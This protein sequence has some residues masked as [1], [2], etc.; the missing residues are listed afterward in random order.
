MDGKTRLEK[1]TYMQ[2]EQLQFRMYSPEE[3]KKLSVLQIN[4]T[5]TFD[6]SGFPISGGLYD[7]RLGPYEPTDV[8]QTCGLTGSDC[9]GHYGHICLHVPVFNPMLFNFTYNLLKGSCV[10]CHQF[11]CDTKGLEANALLAKLYL[12]NVGDLA[13]MAELND[14]FDKEGQIVSTSPIAMALDGTAEA[15]QT[16]SEL[17]ENMYS[18]EK[19]LEEISKKALNSRNIVTLRNGL[20]RDYMRS[21]LFKRFVRCPKCNRRNG[22]MKNDGARCILIDFSAA[23]NKA[24]LKKSTQNARSDEFGAEM[25]AL[26]A[27]DDSKMVA[28]D[29]QSVELKSSL[30]QQMQGLQQGG[31]DKLAWRASEVREHFRLLWKTEGNF[32]SKLFPMFAL[33]GES[34][35]LD[36]LFSDVVLVPPSKFRP[37]RF[38]KGDNYEHPQTVNL[39]RLLESSEIMNA[40]TLLMDPKHQNNMALKHLVSEKATG[41]TPNERLHN[42]YLNLQLRMNAIFDQELDPTDKN[43]PACCRSV[44]TPDPYL[45]VDEIGIPEIFAKKLT[46]PEPVNVFNIT[47]LRKA[48][49]N[50]PGKYPGANAVLAP[51]PNV[52]FDGEK[53]RVKREAT[54]K[55]LRASDGQFNKQDVV[56]RQLKRGDVLLMNRQPSLHK[57]SIMGHRARILKGQRALRMNYA[58]CKA[59]NADFDGDEMNGHLVQNN[60]AQT[61]ARSLANVGS[62]FLVPKDGTP[63]LGLIQDHVVSGVLMT[64]RGQFFSKEDFM[65]LLLAAFAETPKRLKIPPP[66]IIKPCRMWS[67]KQVVSAIV[68]NSLPKDAPPI[69]LI[70]KS[71]TPLVCWQVKGYDPPKME[72]SES[73]I[74]F[75]E[76]ELLCGVL[77]KSHFGATQ[78]GLIHCCFELYGPT[79][80]VQILS[81]FSRVFTT[82]LQFHGFTL[83][84]ADIIV[85]KE[86]DEARTE[87]IKELRTIGEE[88]VRSTFQLDDT[89]SEKKLK[90][91]LATAYNNPRRETQDVQQLDYSMKKSLDPF[92]KRISDACVPSGLIRSF[93]CNALQMMIQSGAKGSM[94]NS[95]QIS[96]G[97]GQ[98]ELEGHRPPLTAAGRTLPSFKAFDPSPRAGGYVDQR[99]LTGIN[100]QE[101]FFHTMAGREGL[102]DTAVKTSRSGYLQRCI[103]KHLEGIVVHYDN[104]VRD[105]DG[106]VIQFRY[107]EDGLDVGRATFLTPKLFPFLEANHKAVRKTVPSQKDTELDNLNETRAQYRKILKYRETNPGDKK[108]YDNAFIRFVNECCVGM[109][110]KEAIEMWWSTNE[111]TKMNYAKQIKKRPDTI[112]E[113]FSSNMLGVLPEKL[114]D[115]VESN[116]D[117]DNRRLKKTLFCKSMRAR[118]DPGE[119]VGLLAAQSIGE[120]STQM[121]LNTFHFAGRGEMNVTLGIPRLREIL[122]TASKNIATPSA[123]VTVKAGT[124]QERIDLIKRELDRVYLKQ[125]LR[126]FSVDEKVRVNLDGSNRVYVLRLDLLRASRRDSAT[127]HLKRRYIMH[128]LEKR[129]IPH[130]AT[131][132]SHKHNEVMKFQQLQ[133]RKL[134]SNSNLDSD[135]KIKKNADDDGMSSDEEAE[136]GREADAAEA[137]LNKRHYDDGEYE[138][139]EDDQNEVSENQKT[140]EYDNYGTDSETEDR[141]NEDE[142]K[143]RVKVEDS[144]RI[145]HVINVCS[146]VSDY[147]Y[148]TTYERWCEVTFRY[149]LTNKTKLDIVSIVEKEVDSF[150]VAETTGIEKCIVREDSGLEGTKQVLQTQGIN[151]NAFYKH[152]DVLDINSIYSNDIHLILNTF[153]V[154]ACSRAIVKEMNN[155]FSVYGIEVSPRHLSLTADYMTFTGFIT[156]FSRGAMA[157]SASPLQKMTF[158]TTLTFLRDSLIIESITGFICSRG[159]QLRTIVKL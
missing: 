96:C 83:G 86:A 102:I 75:S 15:L 70:G 127:V 101:L 136:G 53:N 24:K 122:M 125:I 80:A 104:T 3:L 23:K 43:V 7:L 9:P 58:P 44:I 116:V 36:I 150:I 105:H 82:Y 47:R 119:N 2:M 141:N 151:L 155:V 60:V 95:I 63:I 40:V 121:T 74:I 1:D 140:D 30:D 89:T 48:V 52:L 110:K 107:G 118:V 38:M 13:K 65:H 100:P 120:P 148:D 158:E 59:Y 133:H 77:D 31:Y 126:K 144:S 5:K 22:V 51:Y 131:V 41:R 92:N 14:V 135:A 152:S 93:P 42:A 145:K 11:T 19:K 132:I 33:K 87:A 67:G 138:G 79:V 20:I 129:F 128:E 130:L 16:I 4:Q 84:V 78:F 81:C 143:V 66:T 68:L 90:H 97:L 35:P 69:N 12:L 26:E 61:E 46:F 115:D 123:E 85:E 29:L 6:H 147:K 28:E 72:M 139:E 49:A 88:V 25:D 17:V 134:Q 39:R 73:E 137:R 146:G 55:R 98:I 32:L 71:K 112:E 94:V 156:P 157:A 91:V 124:S 76:G 99:F 27:M 45:D 37:I 109:P 113:K 50:G 111:E 103:I 114:L 10:Q 108:K 54:A 62:N 34:C 149:E 117:P 159:N 106:S 153:G 57:P 142:D 64:M 56:L 21:K 18:D 8:C 154:E